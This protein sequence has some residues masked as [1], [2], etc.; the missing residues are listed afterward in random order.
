MLSRD[1]TAWPYGG[2]VP[3]PAPP[4]HVDPEAEAG[5]A[6]MSPSSRFEGQQDT[7]T[8]TGPVGAGDQ[9]YTGRD[10]LEDP[11][12]EGRGMFARL[13]EGSGGD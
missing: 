11:F 3:P 7:L 10:P 1:L 9:G 6:G 13:H 8:L 2:T 4:L 5:S 12:P